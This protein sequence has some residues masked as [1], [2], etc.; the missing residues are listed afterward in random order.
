M[1]KVINE[2]KMDEKDA[3]DEREEK[4]VEKSDWNVRGETK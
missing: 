1:I 4:I 2:G 3:G